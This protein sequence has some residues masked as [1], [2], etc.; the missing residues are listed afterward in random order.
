ML[1]VK[2]LLAALLGLA[3]AQYPAPAPYAADPYP[4]VPPSYNVSLTI[5]QHLTLTKF[6]VQVTSSGYINPGF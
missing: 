6:F 4:A 5:K 1:S 2:V 3:Q